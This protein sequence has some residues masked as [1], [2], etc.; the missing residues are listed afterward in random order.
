MRVSVERRVAIASAYKTGVS[1]EELATISGYGEE[2]IKKILFPLEKSKK[3]SLE[4]MLYM[5]A[6]SKKKAFNP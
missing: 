1:V 6:K 3:A 4:E 2:T 5:E